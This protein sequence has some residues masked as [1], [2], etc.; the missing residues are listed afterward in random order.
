MP[1]LIIRYFPEKYK[2]DSGERGGLGERFAATL[3]RG[4]VFY[5]KIWLLQ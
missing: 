5:S 2:E 3:S 1:V 4:I